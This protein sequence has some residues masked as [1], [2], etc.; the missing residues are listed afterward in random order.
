MKG[1]NFGQTLA[2][3]IQI[4]GLLLAVSLSVSAKAGTG[5]L[6][7]RVID[8]EGHP[9]SDLTLAVQPIDMI[10]GEMWQVLTPMQQSLTNSAG[11]FRIS[12][13]VVEYAQLV[14][15][16]ETGKFEPDTEI[17]SI[18]IGDLSFLP[19]DSSNL[20]IS[21]EPIFNGG[22]IVPQKMSSV[23]GIPLH[24]KSGADIK[25]ITIKVRPRMRVQC[26]ILS[27][28][29]KPL[30]NASGKFDIHYRSLD[31]VN[32]GNFSMTPTYTDPEGYVVKYVNLPIFCTVSVA[33]NGGVATSKTFRITEEQRHHDLI[34]QLS[35]DST[36]PVPDLSPSLPENVEAP[37]PVPQV[38]D[39][40]GAWAVNP[41][42]GHAYK[43]IRCESWIDARATAVAEGAHLVS[44]ND[45]MEQ[46]WLVEIF[47]QEPFLIGLTR[48]GNQTEWQWTSGE[49]VTYTNWVLPDSAIGQNVFVFVGVT[50]GKWHVGKPDN[51]RPIGV[52]LLEKEAVYP[53][54]A[55]EDR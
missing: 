1:L 16:P 32:S 44:I 53:D 9:V 20:K 43:K 37:P 21:H 55:L 2:F 7:G 6:S 8:M 30:A 24:I 3:L 12:G 4:L 31:G 28:N 29:G 5:T 27:E 33:Y 11:G 47:G 48:L 23:G 17:Y 49:P 38:Q 19:I 50:S 54:E 25:H 35:T 34:L 52:A 15:L 14:V 26:Q 40:I 42:N 10:D 22:N 18:D 45:E 51:L 39:T 13:I 36:L 41:T 46:K